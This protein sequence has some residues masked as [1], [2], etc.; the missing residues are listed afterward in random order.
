MP[1]SF[2]RGDPRAEA[3]M[4]RTKR[5]KRRWYGGHRTGRRVGRTPRWLRGLNLGAALP[6]ILVFGALGVWS[7]DFDAPARVAG[8]TG[9]ASVIDGDSIEIHGRRIRLDRIDA[10]RERPDLFAEWSA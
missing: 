8:I 4:F 3:R 9:V 6:L 10:P 5:P 2:E 1:C 7:H